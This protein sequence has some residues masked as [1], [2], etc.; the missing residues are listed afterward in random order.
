MKLTERDRTFERR[1]ERELRLHAAFSQ[2]Y[3]VR[4]ARPRYRPA[5]GRGMKAPAMKWGMMGKAAAGLIAVEVAQ[6]PRCPPRAAP[7]R[8]MLVSAWSRSSKAAGTRRRRRSASVTRQ[9]TLRMA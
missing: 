3:R 2:Q 9:A 8:L 7:T 1:L 6:P 4:T 5:A